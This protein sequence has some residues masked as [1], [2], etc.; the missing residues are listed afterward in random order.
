MKG[1]WRGAGDK[2]DGGGHFTIMVKKKA[3]WGPGVGGVRVSMRV[4]LGVSHR[5]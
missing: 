2:V 1:R 5:G 4:W 3:G